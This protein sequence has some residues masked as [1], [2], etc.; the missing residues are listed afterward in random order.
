MNN[1]DLFIKYLSGEL[2]R[3]EI[4]L[5]EKRLAENPDLQ[6]EFDRVSAAYK[7][8]EEELQQR[9]E[10][11]FRKQLLEVMKH[12]AAGKAQPKRR[13]PV[14]WYYLLP[15]AASVAIILSIFLRPGSEDLMFSRYYRP[16]NDQVV[17]TYMQGTRGK[18]ETGILHYRLEQHTECMQ[19]MQDLMEEEPQNLRARLYYLLSAIEAGQQDLAIEKLDGLAPN[20]DHPL[21]QAVTWYTA[22][23]Y[24]K[25]DHP[26]EA[27]NHLHSLVSRE[28]PYQEDAIQLEKML[29]K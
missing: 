9:D 19:I 27:L 13:M 12:P 25:S 16:E 4:G 15:L 3:E 22:L 23:A 28:G 8:M 29:L 26:D 2:N 10:E 24:L 7:L 5:F 1:V 18:T 21:G 14:W 11:A 17:L 6:R 20:L